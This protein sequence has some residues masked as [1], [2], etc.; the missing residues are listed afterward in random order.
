MKW[1]NRKFI[2]SVFTV[3]LLGFGASEYGWLE[4]VATDAVCAKVKCDE[5]A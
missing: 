4:P 5:P 2:G 1:K 3:L